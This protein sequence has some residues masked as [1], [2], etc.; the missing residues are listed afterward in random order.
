L[1]ARRQ[2]KPPPSPFGTFHSRR[3]TMSD[4][5]YSTKDAAGAAAQKVKDAG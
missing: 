3:I 2:Q 1:D 4:A 5:W